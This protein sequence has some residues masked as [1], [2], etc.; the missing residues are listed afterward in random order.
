MIELCRGFVQVG[1]IW[2]NEDLCWRGLGVRIPF[3][4]GPGLE[5]KGFRT[6]GKDPRAK[7]AKRALCDFLHRGPEGS[8][9]APA[10]RSTKFDR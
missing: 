2:E 1:E 6:S 3:E 10:A 7:E 4:K 9:Y 8:S 5:V